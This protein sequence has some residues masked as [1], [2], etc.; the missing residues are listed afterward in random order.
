MQG[1]Y[2]T[3]NWDKGIHDRCLFT[4]QQGDYYL[5]AAPQE[6]LT[7]TTTREMAESS[8]ALADRPGSLAADASAFTSTSHLHKQLLA[9]EVIKLRREVAQLRATKGQDSASTSNNDRS[10]QMDVALLEAQKA[11]IIAQANAQKAVL[12][13]EVKN[14]R[15][16]LE[17]SAGVVAPVTTQAELSNGEQA[18]ADALK[19]RREF[20][21][22]HLPYHAV[23]HRTQMLLTT[24]SIVRQKTVE[25]LRCILMTILL[26]C[27]H[28]CR[29]QDS[30]MVKTRQVNNLAKPPAK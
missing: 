14:L 6:P 21:V 17:R 8:S 9:Q 16:E 2:C 11:E 27:M 20:E 30:K 12:A 15:T 22:W 26:F 18:L 13:K 29:M 25:F 23:L 19:R 4:G 24:S 5:A 10:L 1:G 3:V 7:S 28:R